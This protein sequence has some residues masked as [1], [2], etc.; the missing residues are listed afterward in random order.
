V[1]TFA[2]GGCVYDLDRVWSE[3]GVKPPDAEGGGDL[4]PRDAPGDAALDLGPATEQGPLTDG[5]AVP[6][7]LPPQ[8][9][10]GPQCGDGD[11]DSD[12]GEECDGVELNSMTCAL[13]GF[14]DGTLS[15]KGNCFFDKSLCYKVESPSGLQI[16][17][18]A[19]LTDLFPDVASDGT[20]YFVAWS[21]Q[22]WTGSDIYGV[23]VDHLGAPKGYPFAVSTDPANQ[24]YARVAYAGNQYLVPWIKVG[25]GDVDDLFATRVDAQTLTV[26]TL[27]KDFAL[28]QNGGNV[29]STH[30]V[31]ADGS[32]YLSVWSDH[33]HG[34]QDDR[35]VTGATVSTQG[36]VL[37]G[38]IPVAPNT[39]KAKAAPDV[40]FDGTNYLV[41]WEDNRGS[42]W[43]L[44]GLRISPAGVPVGAEFPISTQGDNQRFPA[45]TFD[46]TSYLVVW[47]DDRGMGWDIYGARVTTGGVV[48]S[49]FAVATGIGDQS[50]PDV[51][52]TGAASLVVWDDSSG[53]DDDVRGVRV[54]L[55]GTVLDSPSIPVCTAASS[56]RH[57]AVAAN[58]SGYL[59]VWE[60]TRN[61]DR[62][63]WGTKITVGN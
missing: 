29:I 32:A 18:S 33:Y 7:I 14:D 5:A 1:A 4:L 58:L 12:K 57:P 31:A 16:G 35:Q 28:Y 24:R 40:A 30:A 38:G 21:R 9:D 41:V 56:Q 44:Y 2:V 13:L 52:H 39:G 11:I 8:P 61:T 36:T 43:D 60:D 49:D 62:A 34:A 6:D 25:A 17:V 46:G 53:T 22:T 45:A 50:Q 59:V 63:V 19:V 37:Q 51:A 47:Q 20:D 27:P 55:Q 26:L 10:A 15:C 3:G 54:D 23:G 42:T 48:Q